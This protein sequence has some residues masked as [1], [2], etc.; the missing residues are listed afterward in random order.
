MINSQHLLK[1]LYDR[2]LWHEVNTPLLST[3]SPTTMSA[4]GTSKRLHVEE[5][6][7]PYNSTD[8]RLI[9]KLEVYK[10]LLY[11]LKYHN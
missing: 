9:L 6:K 10:L 7:S 1:D 8:H 3:S 2:S 11:K 4:S 5:R